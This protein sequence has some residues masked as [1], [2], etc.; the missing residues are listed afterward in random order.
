MRM[1]LRGRE[2][3]ASPQPKP[4]ARESTRIPE[5]SAGTFQDTQAPFQGLDGPA[6]AVSP[7]HL[8]HAVGGGCPALAS[9]P[10]SEKPR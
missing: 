5:D 4:Q 7:A 10:R 9:G 8:C 1:G 3:L 6:K 2:S